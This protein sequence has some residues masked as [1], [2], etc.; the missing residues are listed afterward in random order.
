MHQSIYFD[1]S[2]K[3][4]EEKKV[5]GDTKET[6]IEIVANNAAYTRKSLRN[7]EVSQ[8]PGRPVAPLEPLK[9]SLTF[10]P[11]YYRANRGGNGQMRVGL[12]RFWGLDQ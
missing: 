1:T 6:Y 7:S 11:Y 4:L 12:H 2:S 9:E 10:V 5:D 8:M 3:L